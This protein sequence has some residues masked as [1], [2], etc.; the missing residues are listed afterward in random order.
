MA[1]EKIDFIFMKYR[2]SCESQKCIFSLAQALSMIMVLHLRFQVALWN[3]MHIFFFKWNSSV[4][5]TTQENFECVKADY[6]AHGMC[7]IMQLMV[8]SYYTW[9]FLTTTQQI[10]QLNIF[11]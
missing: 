8:R 3:T 5:C 6:R 10:F 9:T 1:S 11:I 7:G 2:T 4:K